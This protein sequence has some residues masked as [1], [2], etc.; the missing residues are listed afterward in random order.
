LNE[1]TLSLCWDKVVRVLITGATGSLGH[2]LVR[3]ALNETDWH[4]IVFS[5]DEKKQAD[6][7][8]LFNDARAEFRLG[9]VRDQARLKLAFY[10]CDVVIHAAALKRV[11]A[12]AGEPVEVFKTNVLGTWNVLQAALSA[13]V[14]KVL[15]ISSDKACH[16]IN[17]YGASK[18]AAEALT[19]SFNQYGYPQGTKASAVR[20][21][22]VLGSRGSV[23]HHWLGGGSDLTHPDMT[24]FIITMPQA[25]GLVHAALDAMEGGEVFVPRLPAARMIDLYQ[26]CAGTEASYRYVGL[27]P[28]GEK[29]HETLLTEE[30]AQR[31]RDLGDYVSIIEPH[32]T[33]WTKTPHW[34]EESRTLDGERRSD[35]ARKLS[36]EQLRE[37]VKTVPEEGV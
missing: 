19:V 24:R 18:F 4:L 34:A 8:A 37:M 36:V 11:D 10:G 33:P 2:A 25:V 28:G 29:M 17:A 35:T 20:Y 1:S 21:G 5:R 14:P 15:V 23:V 31:S 16:P 26:A 22:N 13:R 6:M 12:V 27:R 3:Y 9:D 7:H 30:E 32:L